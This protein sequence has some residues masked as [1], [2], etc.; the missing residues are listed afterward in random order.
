MART[1]LRTVEGALHDDTRMS[2]SDCEAVEE[3]ASGGA[4]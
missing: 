2:H 3:A 1:T 4:T